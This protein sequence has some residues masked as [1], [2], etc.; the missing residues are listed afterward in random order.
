MFHH[1]Q[2]SGSHLP[3]LNRTETRPGKHPDSPLAALQLREISQGL[4]T[5]IKL[6]LPNREIN[7][8]ELHLNTQP[9]VSWLIFISAHDLCILTLPAAVKYGSS[10]FSPLGVWIEKGQL[11]A[12]VQYLDSYL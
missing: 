9:A 2:V 3:G 1:S 7:G 8:G 11:S 12:C 10:D 6:S 5:G 4:A